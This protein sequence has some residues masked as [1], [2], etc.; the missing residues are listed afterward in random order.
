M[1]RP[2]GLRTGSVVSVAHYPPGVAWGP[3]T[4]TDFELVWMLSGSATWAVE[5][6]A[7]GA[8]PGGA[9]VLTLCPG[10]VAL[11]RPGL[12]E[13]YSWDPLRH[14]THAWVHFQLTAPE[15]VWRPM[16]TWPLLRPAR[17]HTVLGALC[18]YLLD[19]AG[20]D[21]AEARARSTDV[22]ALVVDLF[23]TGPFPTQASSITSP[24]V[25]AGLDYVRSRW[26]A[27][28]PDIVPLAE[29][30][31]HVG[32]SAGHLS[33]E[34]HRRFRTGMAGALELARLASAAM[35]LQ[36]TTMTLEQVAAS[37]GF[38]DGYHLSRRF[39][40]AYGVAPGR[41]RRLGPEQDP[42]GP[43]RHADLLAVW[44][45]T[46]GRTGTDP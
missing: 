15:V 24:V 29:V 14:S 39:S 6:P 17:D 26:E 8:R 30:A 33:R 31:G 7:E 23:I 3:R 40:R 45:E 12:L 13:S 19:L 5:L 37:T 22:L 43:L 41:F 35:A 2:A 11:S 10:D 1:T 38:S 27:T 25:R 16:A 20:A 32:V 42:L 44:T 18:D 28:G 9:Q 4:T 36:R 21:T 46:L 34:F